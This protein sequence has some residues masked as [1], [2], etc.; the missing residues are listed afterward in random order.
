MDIKN[1][2]ITLISF[3]VLIAVLFVVGFYTVRYLQ[4]GYKEQGNTAEAPKVNISN[5][6]QEGAK[7]NN[8]TSQPGPDSAGIVEDNGSVMG[9]KDSSGIS[10]ETEKP[11]ETTKSPDKPKKLP[12]TGSDSYGIVGTETSNRLTSSDF[13]ISK[14]RVK[15]IDDDYVKF[16]YSFT[17]SPK[18][19]EYF[20]KTGSN[21]YID[22][23][24]CRNSLSKS[25]YEKIFEATYQKGY[26]PTGIS[27]ELP[28]ESLSSEEN[29]YLE[30]SDFKLM[31]SGKT[32]ITGSVYVP[33]CK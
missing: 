33:A 15:E 3:T 5:E 12:T 22:A 27:F 25:D 2:A 9:S 26:F 10:N 6:N 14:P 13:V 32:I 7:S 28:Q 30:K 1:L 11:K 19:K 17:L 18:A 23:D 21:Y 24:S 4:E 8:N 20:S 31:V 16:E 29:D